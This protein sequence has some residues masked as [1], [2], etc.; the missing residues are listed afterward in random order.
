MA[1]RTLTP[2]YRA[3]RA[4]TRYPFAAAATLTN[5]AGDA[6]L[7]GTLLDAALY[8]VGGAAGL[9]LSAVVVA[10]QA[11]TLWVGNEGDERLCSGT[12]AAARPPDVVPLADALGRPA[13]LLVS[14]ATRLAPLLAWPAGTHAFTRAETEF[15]ASVCVPTPE[16][17]VRGLLLDDGTLL[18]GDVWLVGG[19]GVVLR[20][21]APG[22]IR[23][24]VVGDPLFRRRLC[25]PGAAFA[26]PRPITTLRFLD[27]HGAAFDVTPDAQGN[28]RIAAANAAAHDTVLRVVATEA[29]LRVGAVGSPVDGL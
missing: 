19:E 8:P 15:A 24:D 14:E 28:V 29:G 17:G 12:F 3:A 6:F 23:L 16:R 2:E 18:T 7:E 11:V 5:A 27:P 21:D 25:G 26:V 20:E 10:R 4:E 1:E 13:G 22:T 9:Y